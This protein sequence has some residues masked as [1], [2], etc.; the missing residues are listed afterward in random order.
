MTNFEIRLALPC[1]ETDSN[2][3]KFDDTINNNNN[4]T[5]QVMAEPNFHIIMNNWFKYDE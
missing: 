5:K 2:N 3:L 4:N 1:P